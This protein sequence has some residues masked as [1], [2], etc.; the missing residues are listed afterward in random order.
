LSLH[1]SRKTSGLPRETGLFLPTLTLTH[2]TVA[3]RINSQVGKYIVKTAPQRRLDNERDILKRFRTWPCIR[4]LLDEIEN[5][6]SLVL[7]YLDDNLLH[8]SNTK[9]LERSDVKFVAK[10]VLQAIQALHEEGYTHTGKCT[11]IFMSF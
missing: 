1:R 3:R 5:P 10:R 6:S 7:Q 8:A 9:A 2:L 11:E 4:R